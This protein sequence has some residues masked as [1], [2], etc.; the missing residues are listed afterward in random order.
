MKRA[1][2]GT[3]VI[4]GTRV[5]VALLVV[6]TTA[7]MLTAC[8]NAKPSHT[9]HPSASSA[10]PS[11]S[12]TPTLSPTPTPTPTVT[13]AAGTPVTTKCAVILTAQQVYDYNP[14]VVAKTA[15]T[16]AA[17]TLA[18]HAAAA[19][20]RVCEWVNETSGATLEISVRPVTPHRLRRTC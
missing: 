12:P 20:G 13:A 3:V 18:A 11:P 1:T 14:N 8:V 6:V 5:G 19:S 7:T 16:P 2:P 9:P 17:G 4:R 15:Y 10:S